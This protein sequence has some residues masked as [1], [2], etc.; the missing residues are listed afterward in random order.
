MVKKSGSIYLVSPYIWIIW[1][2]KSKIGTSVFFSVIWH[3][4]GQLWIGHS[5]LLYYILY[6]VTFH[7]VTRLQGIVAWLSYHI[8]TGFFL[9]SPWSTHQWSRTPNYTLVCCCVLLCIFNFNMICISMFARLTWPSNPQIS[10]PLVLVFSPNSRLWGKSCFNFI[11]LVWRL[12][13]FQQVCSG[14]V[15]LPSSQNIQSNIGAELVLCLK[16]HSSPLLQPSALIKYLH[17]G[18]CALL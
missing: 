5:H 7:V 13:L 8:L 15:H 4:I 2:K 16:W 10:V 9:L 6:L 3:G 17:F 12:C 11:P 1:P 14:N 18:T